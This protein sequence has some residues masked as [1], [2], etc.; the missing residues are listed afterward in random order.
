MTR[1]WEPPRDGLRMAL[2]RYE[3]AHIL[4]ALRVAEGSMTEAARLLRMNRLTLHKR[5]LELGL[6]A[7]LEAMWADD[8]YV[9]RGRHHPDR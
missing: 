6:R 4:A 8:G 1:A 9:G 2:R 7:K 3:S 5:I